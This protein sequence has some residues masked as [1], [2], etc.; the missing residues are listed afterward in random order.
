MKEK[1]PELRVVYTRG[2]EEE[3]NICIS[4]IKLNDEVLK[5]F[6][7]KSIKIG[8]STYTFSKS[9]EDEIKEFWEKHGSHYAYCTG[10]KIRQISKLE[11]LS[12]RKTIE[13]YGR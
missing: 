4:S 12:N 10:P 2:A 6:I 7:A 3:G 13:D 8:E 5:N 1:F 11:V 9:T